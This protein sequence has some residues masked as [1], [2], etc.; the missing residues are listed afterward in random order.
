M[1]IKSIEAYEVI[2]SR[3][4]PTVECKLVLENGISVTIKVKRYLC[5]KYRI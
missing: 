2:D 3:S 4:N 1:K 5:K